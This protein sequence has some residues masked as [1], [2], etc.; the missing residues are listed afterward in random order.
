MTEFFSQMI[1]HLF[2]E[3]YCNVNGIRLAVLCR[4]INSIKVVDHAGN[5]C[6]LSGSVDPFKNAGGE[7]NLN[8]TPSPSQIS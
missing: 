4:I 1:R 5:Y 2:D 8:L 3:N 7:C 6:E